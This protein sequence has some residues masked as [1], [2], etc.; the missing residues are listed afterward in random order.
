M[1]VLRDKETGNTIGELT[2]QE[3]QILV[4]AFEE[5]GR[6]DHDYYIDATSP[7]YLENNFEGATRVANLLRT[8]LGDREGF[9]VV[10]TRA[11]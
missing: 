9:D 6:D 10:W 3:L 1:I 8:A 5:E 11:Q 2:P 4:E 7:D